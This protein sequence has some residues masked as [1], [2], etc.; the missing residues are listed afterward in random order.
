[1]SIELAPLRKA[2][3]TLLATWTALPLAGEAVSFSEWRGVGLLDVALELGAGLADVAAYDA[4]FDF[5]STC[6][7]SGYCACV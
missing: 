3:T 2:V 5:P 1:M 7:G 4:L 6:G